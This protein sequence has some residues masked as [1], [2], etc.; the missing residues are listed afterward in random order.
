[1][2]ILCKTFLNK[3]GSNLALVNLLNASSFLQNASR[4]C[5]H[6]LLLASENKS[7]SYQHSISCMTNSVCPDQ[8]ASEEA[9]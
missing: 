7:F 5:H 4:N 2:E 1:M 9:G 8:P 3:Q 6:L